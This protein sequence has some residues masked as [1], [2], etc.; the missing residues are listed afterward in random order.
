MFCQKKHN[1]SLNNRE[2]KSEYNSKR[3]QFF[4][5]REDHKKTLIEHQQSILRAKKEN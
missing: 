2:N 1:L 5:M 3:E 4:K